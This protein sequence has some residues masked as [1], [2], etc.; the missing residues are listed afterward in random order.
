MTAATAAGPFLG[1]P[2]SP[3][4]IFFRFDVNIHGT[5]GF[6]PSSSPGRLEDVLPYDV[7][8]AAPV[9]VPRRSAVPPTVNLRVEHVQH[10]GRHGRDG[11]Q[12]RQR[13]LPLPREVEA[14][15]QRA[16][17]NMW[18]GLLRRQGMSWGEDTRLVRKRDI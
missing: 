13:V 8:Q 6:E 5:A 2:P 9:G 18:G 16:Q 17:V 11:A 14:A 12:D 1:A 4:R 7:G 10:D 3:S 15:I